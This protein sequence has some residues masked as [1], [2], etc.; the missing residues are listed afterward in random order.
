MDG[1]EASRLFARHPWAILPGWPRVVG[2]RGGPHD[3]VVAV[4]SVA[5]ARMKRPPVQILVVVANIQG[6]TLKTEVEKG[7]V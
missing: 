2:G 5:Q 4:Q 6:R 7:S 1:A 3:D